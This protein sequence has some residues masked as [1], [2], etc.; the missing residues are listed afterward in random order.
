MAAPARMIYVRARRWPLASNMPGTRTVGPGH[1][2]CSRPTPRCRRDDAHR[3]IAVFSGILR[4]GDANALMLPPFAPLAA[5]T[6]E[7]R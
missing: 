3:D 5:A 6:E 2:S 1:T 7:P 4:G